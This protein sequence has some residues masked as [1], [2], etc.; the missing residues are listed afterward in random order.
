MIVAALRRDGRMSIPRLA[1]EVG[2]SRA[3]AYARFDRLV[4]AHVITGFEATVDAKAVGLDVAALVTVS[5]D[6]T[7]WR[8]VHDRLEATGGVQ[9]IGMSTGASDFVVLVRAAALDELRD[10][11]LRDLLA[12]DGIRSIETAVLLGESRVPGALI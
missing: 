7:H 1:E 3:T 4:D 8:E 12:I 10:V 2:V 11:V 6:Q 5:A 9:W